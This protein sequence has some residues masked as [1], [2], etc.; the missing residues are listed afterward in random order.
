M[1]REF[2]ESAVRLKTGVVMSNFPGP[3]LVSGCVIHSH[4][5]IYAFLTNTLSV[6]CN[7]SQP[8]STQVPFHDGN[9]SS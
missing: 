3:N 9:T 7:R 4:L 2:I 5:H 6:L 1:A 8:L